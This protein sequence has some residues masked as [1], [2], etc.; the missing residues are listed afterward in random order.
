MLISAKQNS[1]AEMLFELT[2]ESLE[3]RCEIDAGYYVLLSISENT[4]RS[5]YFK[6]LLFVVDNG[7]F[8]KAKKLIPHQ[9]K[10]RSL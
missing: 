8:S 7:N 6:Y 1:Q 4:L 2:V 9:S 5:L 3:L 10:E